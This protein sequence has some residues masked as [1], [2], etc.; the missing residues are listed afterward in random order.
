MAWV[1]YLVMAWMRLIGHAQYTTVLRKL[2][3][4]NGVGIGSGRSIT[5]PIYYRASYHRSILNATAEAL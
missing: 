3:R 4:L 1:A 5:C 2:D